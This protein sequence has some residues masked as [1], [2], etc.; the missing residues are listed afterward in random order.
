MLARHNVAVFY[1]LLQFCP[2][3]PFACFS[4]G[5]YFLFDFEMQDS[6]GEQGGLM[7]DITAHVR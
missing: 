2:L 3:T 4:E 6:T 5:T 1:F 7:Y